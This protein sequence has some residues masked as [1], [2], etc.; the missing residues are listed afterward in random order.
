MDRKKILLVIAFILSV[1]VF[2]YL[3]YYFFF[4]DLLTDEDEEPVQPNVNGIL[5]PVVNGN[6]SVIG[7]TNQPGVL[8]GFPSGILDLDAPSEIA[9]GGLTIVKDY[10]I[11]F[12][13]SLFCDSEWIAPTYKGS[14]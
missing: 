2:G 6:L 10:D 4:S 9:R 14:L 3:L 11:D 8:P 1:F 7:N 12:L 5:P 13:D